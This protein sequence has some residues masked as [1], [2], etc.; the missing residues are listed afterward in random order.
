MLLLLPGDLRIRF[1]LLDGLI[2]NMGKG[3]KA[4]YWSFRGKSIKT[5]VGDGRVR[6]LQWSSLCADPLG[7]RESLSGRRISR[8]TSRTSFLPS[9]IVMTERTRTLVQ[10]AEALQVTLQGPGTE[11]EE[12]WDQTALRH[13]I[14]KQIFRVSLG[15]KCPQLLTMKKELCGVNGQ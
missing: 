14:S 9:T 8:R 5:G 4:W 7:W 15:N 13:L 10:A 2:L 6:R 11:V 3:I 12:D 1:A